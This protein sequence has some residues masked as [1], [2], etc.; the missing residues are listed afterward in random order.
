MLQPF[1]TATTMW[2]IPGD[3]P[4][5]T[6]IVRDQAKTIAAQQALTAAYQGVLNAAQAV[7]PATATGT[8]TGTTSLI[9][10]AVA[11]GSILLGAAVAGTG[12]PVGLT[13]VSQTAGNTGQAG[14]YTTNVATTLT[15]AALTFT[16]SGVAT[17]WPGPTDAPTLTLLQQAQAAILKSQ[18][19]LIQQ[20]QDVLNISETAAP[21]SGP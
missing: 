6:T 10:T 12:V 9:L 7:P 14:T 5:L 20:Y 16:P 4:D 2:P 15:S 13:I 11:N 8:S 19:A 18:T 1:P 17:A 21:P 3:V